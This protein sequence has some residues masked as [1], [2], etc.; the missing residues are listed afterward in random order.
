MNAPLEPLRGWIEGELAMCLTEETI[1]A[2][3][4]SNG[5]LQL[6][7]QSQLPPG[8]VLVTIRVAATVRPKRG[9][10][11]VIREIRADQI[12]REFPGRSAE[13]L[14]AEEEA[15]MAEDAERDRE[16]DAA[17]GGPPSRT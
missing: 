17:R 1:D 11:D 3:L 5:Q 16:L 14:R 12:A 10:A 4:D 2:T 8:P 13:E 15:N 6:A 7:H 9:L